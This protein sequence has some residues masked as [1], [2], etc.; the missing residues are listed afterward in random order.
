VT[1]A[2]TLGVDTVDVG[3]LGVGCVDSFGVGS[4]S[5]FTGVLLGAIDSKIAAN[6]FVLASCPCPVV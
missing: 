6:F 5:L 1:R 4:V 3:A 2:C